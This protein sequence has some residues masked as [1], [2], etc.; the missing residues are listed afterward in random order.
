M[1]RAGL[2]GD[3][4]RLAPECMGPRAYHTLPRTGE[5]P[6]YSAVD[7]AGMAPSLER[8]RYCQ[9]YCIVRLSILHPSGQRC[10]KSDICFL[11]DALPRWNRGVFLRLQQFPDNWNSNEDVSDKYFWALLTKGGIRGGRLYICVCVRH[12]IRN[13]KTD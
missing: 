4:G 10:L 7:D 9:L 6:Q 5:K 8:L 2:S 3:D 13:F 11:D 1:A 12:D